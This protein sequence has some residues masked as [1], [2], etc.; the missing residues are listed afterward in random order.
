MPDPRARATD[1]LRHFQRVR[2]AADPAAP[3]RRLA[4][5]PHFGVFPLMEITLAPARSF[6][7]PLRATRSISRT[8]FSC[9]FTS[10][11]IRLHTFKPKD[12]SLFEITA[13]LALH[14]YHGFIDLQ[15]VS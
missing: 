4:P 13:T 6:R 15:S 1:P 5:T 2:L 11:C 7:S 12:A 10:C 14:L 9:F 3:R 8:F